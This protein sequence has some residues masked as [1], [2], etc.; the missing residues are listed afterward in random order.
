MHF[1]GLYLLF[2]ESAMISDILIDRDYKS[3]KFKRRGESHRK[4]K[5]CDNI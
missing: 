3:E 5:K 2:F 1:R 4:R